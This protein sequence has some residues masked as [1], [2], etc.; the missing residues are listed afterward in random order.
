MLKKVLSLLFLFLAENRGLPQE[1]QSEALH[2]KHIGIL[3][4][5]ALSPCASWLS[6]ISIAIGCYL[7]SFG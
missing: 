3:A 2:V 4:L 6:S 7:L 1:H 5:F